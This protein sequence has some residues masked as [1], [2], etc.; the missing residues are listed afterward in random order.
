MDESSFSADQIAE[1]KDLFTIFDKDGD[2]V[3]SR[4]E[5]GPMMQT[6]GL[7]L[8]ERELDKYFGGMDFNGDNRIEF[9]ELVEFLQMIARPISVEEELAQAFKYFQPHM[10]QDSITKRS[11]ATV[12]TS[13]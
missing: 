3:I 6:L 9:D 7:K 11:L 5:F 13:M 2:G 12:L 10:G 4:E 1:C 8:N